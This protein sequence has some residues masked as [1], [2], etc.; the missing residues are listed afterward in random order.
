MRKLLLCVCFL[1]G[2]E[3]TEQHRIDKKSLEAI[4][5]LRDCIYVKLDPGGF[6][7]DM[8]VIRCPA[9]STTVRYHCGKGCEQNITV[10]DNKTK[11]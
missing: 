11:S 1:L 9:S 5:E 3:G 7:P 4:P 2:C 8:H 6:A 10:V